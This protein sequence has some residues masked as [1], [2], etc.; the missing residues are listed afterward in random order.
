MQ[1]LFWQKNCKEAL[2]ETKRELDNVKIRAINA[3]MKQF[4][5]SPNLSDD[6]LNMNNGDTADAQSAPRY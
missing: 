6:S 3:E 5:Q 2:E 4:N 1:Y